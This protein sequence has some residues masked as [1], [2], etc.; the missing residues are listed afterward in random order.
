MLDDLKQTFYLKVLL[1]AISDES[2]VCKNCSISIME[3]INRSP[4]LQR[5]YG[6]REQLVKCRT[7]G[8]EVKCSQ[9]ANHRKLNHKTEQH[10][11]Y[12]DV[13][14]R[15]MK[16]HRRGIKHQQ[17]ALKH[18]QIL[19]DLKARCDSEN[20][21]IALWIVSRDSFVRHATRLLS[22]SELISEVF[23]RL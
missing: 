15:D 13:D 17:P 19:L 3:V 14:E 21:T 23:D 5:Y 18:E 10:C 20:D 8:E 16:A 22:V 6:R 4:E 7:C 11:E 12:C 2:F 1:I 9:L